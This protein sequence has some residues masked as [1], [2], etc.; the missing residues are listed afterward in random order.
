MYKI[1]KLYKSKLLSYFMKHLFLDIETM[2]LKITHEDV[3][4]YLMDKKITKEKRSLDPNY[5]QIILIGTKIQD[6]MNFFSGE[7]KTML[8]EFWSYVKEKQPTKIITYNGYK[9]DIPFLLLRS[10]MHTIKVPININMNR[11]NMNSSNH[12]DVMLFFSHNEIF[13]NPN[14]EILGKMHGIEIPGEQIS[15]RDIEKL[16]A[17]NQLDT[18]NEKCKHDLEILEQ[19]FEK[20]CFPSLQ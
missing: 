2:P 3:K 10:Y 13:L 15:G 12:F 17:Q 5:S 4:T 9:F 1:R 7:E 19:L 6:E 20:I 8:Q 18:I 14:L 16:Y 11:W